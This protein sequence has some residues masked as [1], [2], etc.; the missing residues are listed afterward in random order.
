MRWEDINKKLAQGAACPKL[1]VTGISM[2]AD[3]PTQ[4]NLRRVRSRQRLS[5]GPFVRL[6]DAFRQG[7]REGGYVEGRNV[8]IAYRGRT[9]NLRRSGAGSRP[10]APS[11]AVIAANKTP[12]MRPARSREDLDDLDENRVLRV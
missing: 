8:T 9:V 7:L 5:P 11:G 12:S 6:A 3:I 2:A 10:G 1:K 4:W